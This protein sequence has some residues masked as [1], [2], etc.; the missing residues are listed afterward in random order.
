MLLKCQTDRSGKTMQS[1]IR[2]KEQSRG[3]RGMGG[4]WR[5]GHLLVDL[6]PI[7]EQKK[8]NKKKTMRKGTFFSSWAVHSAVI[9]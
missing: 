7:L 3:G 6:V 5:G 4:G 9:V 2:L 8:K 1:Q